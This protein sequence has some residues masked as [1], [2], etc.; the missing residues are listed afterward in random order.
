MTDNQRKAEKL[1]EHAGRLRFTASISTNGGHGEDRFLVRLADRLERDA[2]E[3]EAE[4]AV[5]ETVNG[6]VRCP[7]IQ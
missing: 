4:G 2:A 6:P 1:R 3:L 7:P 5:V